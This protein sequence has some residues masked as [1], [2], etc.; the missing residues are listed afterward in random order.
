MFKKQYDVFIAYHGSYGNNGT[1]GIAEKLYDHLS[2]LG[3]SVFFFPKMKNDAFKANIIDVMKSKT[4]ILVC[5]ENLHRYSNGKIN[6]S[7]HYEL[8]TEIDAFYALTQTGQDVSVQDSKIL[9]CDSNNWGKEADI[10]ELFA[11]RPHFHI[12][13]NAITF[14]KIDKWLE[15]RISKTNVIEDFIIKYS[16][17]F[18]ERGYFEKHISDTEN[19]LL[20]KVDGNYIVRKISMCCY[21]AGT[22]TNSNAVIRESV[23]KAKKME[24]NIEVLL[25]EDDEFSLELIITNPNSKAASEA[26]NN[27]KIGN[28][29]K[30]TFYDSY[31]KLKMKLNDNDDIYSER[32]G[33]GFSCKVTDISLPYAIMQVEYKTGY[34][35]LNHIKIDLYSP[36]LKRNKNSSRLTIIVSQ[37]FQNM[38]YEYFQDQLRKISD[39]AQPLKEIPLQSGGVY[40]Q[41]NEN[42]ESSLMHSYRQYLTGN[43]YFDRGNIKNNISYIEAGISYYK[44]FKADKPHYHETTAE[45]YIILDGEQK[46]LDLDE[47]IQYVAKKGDF[48]FI[49]PWTKHLTKNKQGTKI[50]FAKAPDKSDKEIV[51]EYTKLDLNK[52][53]NSYEE[54]L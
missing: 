12:S 17:Q 8:S 7:K 16:G 32:W 40:I 31:N 23:N 5:N 34:E 52:W 6:K 47:Q 13:E 4:F 15:E 30:K 3:Y 54:D 19:R 25:N 14:S 37:K 48:I 10:H 39:H 22:V 46:I 9:M 33:D 2:K 1:T 49:P 11:N 50:F 28:K 44:Y 45:H 53:C 21:T 29:N 51:E 38:E 41:K 35:H 24:N 18:Y 43:T 20:Q 26:I 42:I 27:D 36:Y